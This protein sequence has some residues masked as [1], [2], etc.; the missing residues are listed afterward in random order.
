MKAQVLAN[1]CGLCMMAG[2]KFWFTLIAD[3][4]LLIA[5]TDACEKMKLNSGY[6]YYLFYIPMYLSA[7]I[8]NQIPLCL[9]IPFLLVQATAYFMN[10]Q[11]KPILGPY[12]SLFLAVLT[13]V[14]L[15]SFFSHP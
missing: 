8:R 1:I 2:L 4:S 6:W 12:L 13:M 7:V 3:N 5:N 14:L 10:L 15:S 11:L 9:T